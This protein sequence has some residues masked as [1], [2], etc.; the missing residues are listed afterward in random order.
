MRCLLGIHKWSG[1]SWKMV[2]IDGFYWFRVCLRCE[3]VR[4]LKAPCVYPPIKFVNGREII[5][6]D[7]AYQTAMK[8][9]HD[10]W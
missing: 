7:K 2:G 6:S 8:Q 1:P 10:V 4:K 5:I 9:M 3:K